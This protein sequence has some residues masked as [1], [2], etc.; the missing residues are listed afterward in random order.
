MKNIILLLLGVCWASGAASQSLVVKGRVLDAAN[1][2]ALPGATVLVMGQ[3]QAVLSDENGRFSLSG[4]NHLPVNLVVSYVGFLTDTINIHTANSETVIRLAASLELK[5]AE[6]MARRQSTE[7]STLQPRNIELLNEGELLKAACCNLSESFETNPSV[8]VNYTDAVTGAR[9]IQLLGLSGNYTMFMSEAIPTLRGMAAPYG[10]MYIPGSWM[11]SI[12]ITK[13]AGSVANGYEGMT[14]QINVEFKKPMEEQPLLHLNLYGDAFGRG[15]MNA[16]YTLPLK[17]NWGYMFMAHAS[18]LQT[19]N[20]ANNDKFLDMPLYR[21]LNVYNR[22]HYNSRKRLEG[23]FGLKAMLEDRTGGNVNFN[24]ARDKFTT[25]AYGFRIETRRME[26]YSKT[27][28]VFP[29]KPYKSTGL[30]LSA[31]VHDQE[32]YFGLTSYLGAQ[33]SLYGNLIYMSM[34]GNTYHKFKTGFDYRYDY[35]DEAVDDSVF[36]R[37]ESVPGAYLEYTYGG[38]DKKF[39]AIAGARVDHH[40]L[41][42]WLFTPRVH[43]KYN[44]LPDL[45]LRAS[46]GRAYRT[47]NTYSDNIGLFVSSKKLVLLEKPQMEDAWNGGMNLTARFRLKGREGSLM[48]DAYHTSFNHQWMADQYSSSAVVYYY[49]LKGNSSANSLQATL[50]YEPLLRLVMKAAWR[51][52]DVKADYLYYPD[53]AKP[54]LSRNKALF[55]VAYSDRL[56]RW[57]LDATLQWEGPKPMPQAAGE[58]SSHHDNTIAIMDSPDFFQLMAQLTRVFKTWE[59][60]LG[61]ENILNYRQKNVIL[62]SDNPFGTDFDATQVWGPVV[63]TRIYAG[64][65]LNISKNTDK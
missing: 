20:D 7:I 64:L 60:Y 62:G 33:Y 21:Q 24:E 27:G 14:G 9:E 25:N 52:D 40:N 23:Q 65:R 49:N 4:I 13:G 53:L 43:L 16:I 58:E 57:R 1:N 19:K 2:S 22:L 41:F 44:F 35:Y 56:E 6:I 29:E 42:G 11:E 61:A 28:M 34:V 45:I 37:L 51:F 32:A 59:V 63:G 54:M 55:N 8:D 50:T 39:G 26:V 15:E 48:L 3:D 10:L 18:G 12:Q 36:T 46:A 5:A 17:K 31:T 30:Q 38:D 47:P